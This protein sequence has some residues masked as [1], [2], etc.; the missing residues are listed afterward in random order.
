MRR[1]ITLAVAAAILATSLALLPAA[2]AAATKVRLTT[3]ERS[4]LTLINKERRQ[5]GLKPLRVNKS[6]TRAAR[7][8]SRD[9]ARSQYFSHVSRNGRTPGQRVKA[10]GYSPSSCRRWNVGENIAWAAGA[11]ATARATVRGWMRSPSH[12]RLILTKCFRDVGIG[13]AT[14]S[15][16]S[17]GITLSDVTYYTLDLGLRI[18]R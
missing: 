9:M 4:V 2:S 8:H 16:T 7:A 18:R 3:P 6:L 11:Y 10:R 5:R 17:G 14:G 13:T 1:L 15:L 12:R